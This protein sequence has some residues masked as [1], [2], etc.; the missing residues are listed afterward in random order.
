MASFRV[1]GPC[2][3]KV[4]NTLLGVTQQGITIRIAQAAMPIIDDAHGSVPAAF[5]YTGRNAVVMCRALDVGSFKN[6]WIDLLKNAT[7]AV[8]E[9]ASNN[10]CAL[11]I[12][13]RGSSLEDTA[14][15][16]AEAAVL[17]DPSPI[18][19]RATQE[20]RLDVSFQ[21]IPYEYETGKYRLFKEY[22]L[23]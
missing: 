13:E 20:L 2:T 4:D 10:S 17:I 3:I 6:A 12:W 23:D 11:E 14:D 18:E 8:G 1:P 16:K 22:K 19:L 7:I 15:W 5:I 21:V 9:L